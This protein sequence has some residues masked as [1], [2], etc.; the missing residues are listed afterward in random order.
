MIGNIDLGFNKIYFWVF[1]L[2]LI[3]LYV[4]FVYVVY[5]VYVVNHTYKFKGDKGHS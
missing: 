5:V 2:T 4:Y 1:F 3:N